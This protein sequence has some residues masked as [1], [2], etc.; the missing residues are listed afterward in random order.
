MKGQRGRFP[1]E[2]P[3]ASAR[4][5]RFTSDGVYSPTL[6]RAS[7]GREHL[8]SRSTLGIRRPKEDPVPFTEPRG[9]SKEVDGPER[10][11]PKEGV[12]GF[13]LHTRSRP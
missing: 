9:P 13:S 10:G 1:E 6:G 12:N 2:A 11:S 4:M 7:E 5:S 3:L 8:N